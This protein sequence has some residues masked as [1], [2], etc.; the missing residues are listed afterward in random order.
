METARTGPLWR[1]AS[2]RMPTRWGLFEVIGYERDIRTALSGS[3][4]RSR[5]GLVI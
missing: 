5:S 4:P 3:K 1:I 2:T